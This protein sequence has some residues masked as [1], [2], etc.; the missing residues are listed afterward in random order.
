VKAFGAERLLF[1]TKFPMCYTGGQ[2]LQLRHALD[3]TEAEKNA[4]AGENLA[5][6]WKEAG[7]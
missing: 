1:G 6:L 2:M 7:L 3:V 5:R 4:I